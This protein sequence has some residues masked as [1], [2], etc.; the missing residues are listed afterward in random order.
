[1]PSPEIIRIREVV[2]RDLFAAGK[3]DSEIAIALKLSAGTVSLY[4]RKLGLKRSP[5]AKLGT[6]HGPRFPERLAKIQALRAEGKSYRTI[7]DMV[8]LNGGAVAKYF[9]YWGSH[10]AK[11][12]QSY[13]LDQIS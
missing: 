11:E 2:I 12:K 10:L 7:G 4:R 3:T 5:G 9:Q 13:G 8:G 1:M 6:L